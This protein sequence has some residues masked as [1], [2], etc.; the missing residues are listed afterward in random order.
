MS[1]QSESVSLILTH[2][3]DRHPSVDI[4]REF[5]NAVLL[6]PSV[7]A[8]D[9]FGALS[10]RASYHLWRL[11]D[12]LGLESEIVTEV[13]DNRLIRPRRFFAILMGPNFQEC[14]PY[15]CFPGQKNIYI[16]DAWPQFH[17]HIA[18]F[19]DAFDPQNIFFSSSQAAVMLQ[20]RLRKTRCH[21]IPEGID[22]TQ[23][24]FNSYARKDI[25]VLA[26]GRRYD[27]Y[28]HMIVLAL[29][30]NGKKYLY[31]AEPGEIVFPTREEFIDGLARAKIS[32]CVP[33]NVTHPERAGEIETMT[34]RYLQSM[35]SKCLIVGHAP[36]EMITLFG[37]NPVI[38]IDLNNAPSQLVSII[39]NYHDHQ[40]LIERNFTAVIREHSWRSRWT[41][42]ARL[43]A[44]E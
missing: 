11:Q 40:P 43:I 23:Y 28:H 13:L 7:A 16:F 3:A 18:R 25:D 14:L 24:K 30:N 37:Y 44:G 6:N 20:G 4:V 29:K 15:F 32:I 39:D 17:E 1:A 22:S 31:E 5:Q 8:D 9:S 42:I 33:S 26:M 27:V 38:E 10:S 19:A 2:A 12:R 21:W 35:A 36:E 41:R 34:A